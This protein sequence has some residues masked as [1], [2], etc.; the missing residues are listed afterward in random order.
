MSTRTSS[1]QR[2]RR[3][4]DGH[5]T[6]V[7]AVLAALRRHQTTTVSLLAQET[8]Y[9]RPT[10]T[11][12]LDE[13]CA[14]SLAEE[15]SLS[16]QG[17]GRPATSWRIR[18]DAGIIIGV[19]LLATSMLLVVVNLRGEVLL[20]HQYT[21]DTDNADRRL[22]QLSSFIHEAAQAQQDSGRLLAVGVSATG[23]VDPDGSIVASDFVPVWS[24]F[25]LAER[26][27]QALG[28]QVI[29]ENDINM[30]AFGEYTLRYQEHRVEA[31]SCLFLA[32]F[33]RGPRTGLILDGQVHRGRRWKAGEISELIDLRTGDEP[34]EEW[35]SRT[36]LAIATVSAVLDPDIVVLSASN[37]HMRD[38]ILQVIQRLDDLQGKNGSR[39]R[40]ELAELEGAGSVIGAIHTALAAAGTILTGVLSPTPVHLT[41]TA[42]ITAASMKGSHSVMNL[43][44]S[45][46]KPETLRAG[47]VGVGARSRFAL[48]CERPENNAHITAVCDPHPL[49]R[50]RVRERLRR[51]PDSLS[52]TSSVEELVKTGIDIAFVTSPDDTHASVTC[53][54]LEAGIPVYLEKPLAIDLEGATRILQTAYR[55]GTGLYVGHN[56]RH[57]NV[58]RSMRDIIRSGRI[59]EVKA[60]W[61][62]HFV[63][64]G[65]DYYFK[66]WHAERSHVG[67]LLLQKAAHDIDVMH[68][69]ADSHTTEVV[70]MGGLTLYDQ[71]A[72]RADNSDE[73]MSDWFATSH[74]PPLAQERLN[75]TIDVEDLSMMLMRMESGVYAS[76]QQCHYTPDYWRNYTVI[77]TEGRI[78][79]FGDG[80]G[81]LIRLWASRSDYSPDGDTSFPILGDAGGHSDA[82]V[83]TVT[84]FIRFVRDGAP[85]DT[86]PLGAWYA[87]AA[88]IQATDSLRHGSRP[89]QIPPLP[90]DLINYFNN[91]QRKQS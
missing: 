87:V 11:A 49:V 64:H 78:E 5:C 74:W 24:G 70:A 28:V 86:S 32:Q 34:D 66:D 37:A 61:C 79:N 76:Y 44:Q 46:S 71:V 72:S 39:I 85:T 17:V 10:V 22:S 55:T 59:G 57:M 35:M 29:V 38:A 8:G 14:N 45:S 6:R 15:A 21:L 69:L 30:A 19:D 77:G 1:D 84:E 4:T 48:A 25:P 47:I 75:P 91:N 90:D 58:V 88:G 7:D 2:I 3:R 83:L 31:D 40:L 42:S 43:F 26:L 62:R 56:M 51:D 41:G 18:P 52:V 23:V 27:A 33:T 63:G 68:W 67:G 53:D 12:T 82:D 80:E 9:S 81:G 20:A 89:E 13:L 16:D 65:G 54:L 60:I 50:E 73:L 36:A